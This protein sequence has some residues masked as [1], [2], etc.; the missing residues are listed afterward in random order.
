MPGP[1]DDLRHAIEGLPPNLAGEV[2]DFVD[3]VRAKHGLGAAPLAEDRLWLD[4]DLS[5]IG[6]LEPEDDIDPSAGQLVR[7]DAERGEFVVLEA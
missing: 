4:A 3:F 1:L 6:E 2:L 5:R 7:W